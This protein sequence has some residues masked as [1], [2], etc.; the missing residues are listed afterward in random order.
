MGLKRLGMRAI[1]FPW[2]REWDQEQELSLDV[3]S[4]QQD[5][6]GSEI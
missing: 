3:S 6:V 2:H 5:E 4:R 1:D